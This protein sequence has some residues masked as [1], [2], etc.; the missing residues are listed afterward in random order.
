MDAQVLLFPPGIAKELCSLGV[1]LTSVK[2][3]RVPIEESIPTV[4]LIQIEQVNHFCVFISQL[5]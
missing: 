4:T 2:K 5:F 3:K 1:R